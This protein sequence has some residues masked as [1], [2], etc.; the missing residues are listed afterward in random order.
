MQTREF[1][2]NLKTLLGLAEKQRIAIMCA[3]VLPWRCHRFLIA[4]ALTVKGVEVKH[5]ISID[6]AIS[7]DLTPW[8]K[9][10]GARITY[11]PIRELG[12]KRAR[13]C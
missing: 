8:I 3:E 5:I 2:E 7:H 9:I 4:D 13:A 6:K 12:S 10:D 1:E 11:P